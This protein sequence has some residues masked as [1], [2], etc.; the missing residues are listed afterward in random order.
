MAYIFG[1][2]HYIGVSMEKLNKWCFVPLL[3]EELL[4]LFERFDNNVTQA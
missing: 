4:E 3:S 2:L 1:A